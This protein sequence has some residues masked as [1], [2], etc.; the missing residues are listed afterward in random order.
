[1][2]KANVDK[3]LCIG[4]GL[5]VGISGNVFQMND[6]GKAESCGEIPAGEEAAVQDAADSC[7]VSAILC[8]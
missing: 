1:M 6:A 5:C 7:P 4:C 3:S 2:M 8:E